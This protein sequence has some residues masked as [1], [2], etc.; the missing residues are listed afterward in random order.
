LIVLFQRRHAGGNRWSRDTEN[1]FQ[2]P[3][4]TGD[5]R[6]S[7]SRRRDQQKAGFAEQPATRIVFFKCDPSEV[8][9]A[10]VGSSVVPRKTL[11]GK[12]VVCI[13]QIQDAAVLPNDCLD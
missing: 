8:A 9:S 10:D 4:S 6:S 7:V 11:I 3:L 1:V 12:R 2:N 13:Q 5:G